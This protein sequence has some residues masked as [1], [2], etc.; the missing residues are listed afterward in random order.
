[1]RAAGLVHRSGFSSCARTVLCSR[2]VS[3]FDLRVLLVFVPSLESGS[4]L[5]FIKLI[6]FCQFLLSVGFPVGFW[7]KHRCS[8]QA[9]IPVRT[10]FTCSI[11]ASGPLL[12]LPLYRSAGRAHARFCSR[13]ISARRQSSGTEAFLFLGPKQA[14]AALFVFP[15]SSIPTISVLNLAKLLLRS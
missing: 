7:G 1:V 10:A 13:L 15:L 6:S 2:F 12:S 3:H 14:A 4:G 8:R 11:F 5:N 9:A